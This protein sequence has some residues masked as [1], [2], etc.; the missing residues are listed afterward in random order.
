M[1]DLGCPV[2][3]EDTADWDFGEAEDGGKRETESGWRSLQGK[4]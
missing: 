4:L 3:V 2:L 1:L